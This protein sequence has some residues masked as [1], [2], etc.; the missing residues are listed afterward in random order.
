[1]ILNVDASAVFIEETVFVIVPK[2]QFYPKGFT[3]NF[4]R[5]NRFA[6]FKPNHTFA[7]RLNTCLAIFG[8]HDQ[9]GYFVRWCNWQH[10]WFWSRKV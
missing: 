8:Q 10:I 4:F 6:L 3:N 1:M 5:K 2:K 7:P 9:E